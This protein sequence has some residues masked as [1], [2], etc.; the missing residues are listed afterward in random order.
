MKSKFTLEYPAPMH[1]PFELGDKVPS[2]VIDGRGLKHRFIGWAYVTGVKTVE[3]RSE[4]K[5]ST[6]LEVTQH[7]SENNKERTVNNG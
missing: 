5:P 4:Y 6:T 3:T 7:Y 2:G 1:C